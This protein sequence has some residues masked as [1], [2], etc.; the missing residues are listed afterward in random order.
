MTDTPTITDAPKKRIRA[1]VC[2]I[3]QAAQR[4]IVERGRLGINNHVVKAEVPDR[5]TIAVGTVL[6]KM[7]KRGEIVPMK[8]KGQLVHWFANQE[9]AYRWAANVPPA[10]PPARPAKQRP[11][12]QGRGPFAAQPAPRT[13][14]PQGPTITPPGLAPKR[15]PH[16][17]HDK[18]YQCAPGERPAG[19]GFAAAGIG[20]DI[21]TGQAW[22]QRA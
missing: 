14:Q 17:T 19:A 16:W 9:L 1:A 11:T 2:P 21:T 7:A 13:N 15:V 12:A 3:K 10:P 4:L 5:D 22:G 6:A 18:R 8:V 20:R